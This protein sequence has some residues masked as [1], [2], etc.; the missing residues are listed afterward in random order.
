MSSRQGTV[1]I[2]NLDRREN[3]AFFGIPRRR[4]KPSRSKPSCIVSPCHPSLHHHFSMCHSSNPRCLVWE[5]RER[6]EGRFV[7]GEKGET[8]LSTGNPLSPPSSSLSNSLPPFHRSPQGLPSA[9]FAHR[10]PSQPPSVMASR[11]ALQHAQR[12]D[13]NSSHDISTSMGKQA[14]SLRVLQRIVRE[15]R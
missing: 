5:C 6:E 4:F 10:R 13:P 7:T 14:L 2:I 15:G 8:R 3:R 1:Q 9:R 11:K 12:Q